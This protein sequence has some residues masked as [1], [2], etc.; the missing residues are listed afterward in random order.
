MSDINILEI[1]NL[2]DESAKKVVD[3]TEKI[4]SLEAQLVAFKERVKV[5]DELLNGITP[6]LDDAIESKVE[7]PLLSKKRAPR[8][9]KLEMDRRRKVIGK[10]LFKQ[11]DMQPKDLVLDMFSGSGTTGH[12]VMQAN[13][14]DGGNRKFIL[15]E[16]GSHFDSVR[17]LGCV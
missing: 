13:R 4:Q 8:S 10:I 3:I 11:G 15:L 9:T 16:S 14:N 1:R 17:N 6:T 2:R 12:A 5:Y 7:A